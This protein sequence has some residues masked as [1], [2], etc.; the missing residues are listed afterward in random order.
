MAPAIFF[1]A[2][3]S[4]AAAGGLRRKPRSIKLLMRIMHLPVSGHRFGDRLGLTCQLRPAMTG[5][6]FQGSSAGV[7][8]AWLAKR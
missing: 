3:K 5:K 7:Q 6:N 1:G 4:S 8:W 2:V